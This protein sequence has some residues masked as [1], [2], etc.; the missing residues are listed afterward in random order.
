MYSNMSRNVVQTV[1]NLLPILVAAESVKA[2][3]GW[4]YFFPPE[5]SSDESWFVR[6]VKSSD[7]TA[8]RLKAIFGPDENLFV[9]AMGL[10]QA[11]E[12]QDD[13]ALRRASEKVRPYIRG[14]APPE[15]SALSFM[16]KEGRKITFTFKAKW[17]NTRWNYCGLMADMFKNAR[18]VIWYPEKQERF[19]PGLYCPDWK[20]A[21]FAEIFLGRIRVCPKC[22]TI[23]IPETDNVDYCSPKCR[24]A[25]RVARWRDRKEQEKKGRGAKAVAPKRHTS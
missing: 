20:T 3:D 12:A 9:G 19:V 15:D 13:L 7:L 8:A 11:Y 6:V 22:S 24:E 2:A 18:F 4:G 5:R 10:K 1:T 14:Y 17:N 16:A 25:H 23:F 21:A